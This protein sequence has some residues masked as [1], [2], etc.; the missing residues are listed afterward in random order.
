MSRSDS[1]VIFPSRQLYDEYIVTGRL[2]FK[3]W[4]EL[5][6]PLWNC[7]RLR[8]MWLIRKL[9]RCTPERVRFK[10]R[11]TSDRTESH[12][13]DVF[14]APWNCLCTFTSSGRR[15]TWHTAPSPALAGLQ[16]HPRPCCRALVLGLW[17][18]SVGP[19]VPFAGVILW[20]RM[21]P[22]ASP[23]LERWKRL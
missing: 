21:C 17:F 7:A 16:K 5:C 15:W 13:N 9:K 19:A 11:Y 2:Y 14:P 10:R 8:R 12:R 20:K 1:L 22:F 23:L 4:W 6:W 18:V 3:S